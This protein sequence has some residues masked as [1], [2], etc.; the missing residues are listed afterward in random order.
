MALNSPAPP[1]FQIVITSEDYRFA[2]IRCI[3]VLQNV[4]FR[5]EDSCEKNV[6]ECSLL[7]RAQEENRKICFLKCVYSKEKSSPNLT[8]T[9][10]PC[11]SKVFACKSRCKILNFLLLRSSCVLISYLRQ[12]MLRHNLH[13]F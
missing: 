11:Y 9:N 3:H 4:R 10:S 7:D 13:I 1:I 12:Q 2:T 6:Q 5:V 8:K